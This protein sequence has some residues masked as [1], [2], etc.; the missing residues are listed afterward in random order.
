MKTR[1]FINSKFATQAGSF[2]CRVLKP[3]IASPII[4]F[5]SRF[6]TSQKSMGIVQS[7]RSNLSVV[8]NTSENDPQIEPYILSIMEN[9]IH[10]LYDLFR[11]LDKPQVL[12]SKLTISDSFRQLINE[13]KTANQGLLI[14][15]PHMGNFDLTGRS[16]AMQGVDLTIL[17]YPDPPSGYIWQNKLREEAGLEV[18]PLSI[19]ALRTVGQRLEEN[20][21][22][23][24]GVDRPLD[25]TNYPVP[26][27]GK[28]SKIPVTPVRLA[29]KHK[30]KVAVCA[31]IADL[32]GSYTVIGSEKLDL[33]PRSNLA[34]ELIDNMALILSKVEPLIQTYLN[35][36]SMFYKIWS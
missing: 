31:S 19:P 16:L 20:K 5:I 35:Q 33:T 12:I 28:L 27:F 23:V 15:M 32:K 22:V 14:L 36:W 8:L 4:R 21:I 17:S 3:H 6:I 30:A 1:S 10:G 2:L 25:T 29:I 13:Q 18:I 11:N 34:H 24:T 9:Q 7:L 26:F